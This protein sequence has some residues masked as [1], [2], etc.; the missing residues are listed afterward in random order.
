VGYGYGGVT[1]ET[2]KHTT[3][4]STVVPPLTLSSHQYPPVQSDRTNTVES[5]YKYRSG[6]YDLSNGADLYTFREIKTE[7]I[8]HEP[9]LTE[10]IETLPSIRN[11]NRTINSELY[12][13]KDRYV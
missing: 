11:S 8:V 6:E 2:N 5:S 13:A 4:R 10:V 9:H 3:Q 1:A 7:R 12:S